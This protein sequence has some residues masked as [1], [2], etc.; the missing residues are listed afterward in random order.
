MPSATQ[1]E[2]STSKPNKKKRD[3]TTPHFM[4]MSYQAPGSAAEQSAS[5]QSAAPSAS[6]NAQAK[7]ANGSLPKTATPLPVIGLLGFGT[8]CAGLVVRFRKQAAQLKK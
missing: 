8:L 5:G 7:S 2:Q 1:S 3:T 6:S 4:P